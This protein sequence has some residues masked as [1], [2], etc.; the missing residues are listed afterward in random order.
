MKRF[1]RQNILSDSSVVMES[2][3][4]LFKLIKTS[5]V[6]MNKTPWE[7]YEVRSFGDAKEFVVEI[8]L[9]SS[10]ESFDGPDAPVKYTYHDLYIAHGMRS[11][12]ES[13]DETKRY[14]EVLQ[15][16]LEFAEKIKASDIITK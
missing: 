15:S 11:S 10:W 2:P 16:A 12:I 1:V 9:R 14:I 13:L 7:G 5:G 4:G 6:G 3:D 8:R